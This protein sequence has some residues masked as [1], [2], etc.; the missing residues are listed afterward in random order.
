LVE[1]KLSHEAVFLP[2]VLPDIRGIVP[3]SIMDVETLGK[4]EEAESWGSCSGIQWVAASVGSSVPSTFGVSPG[5]G[6]GVSPDEVGNDGVGRVRRVRWGRANLF[7]NAMV[8]ERNTLRC[9]L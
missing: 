4:A 1:S 2:D 5:E 7:T 8:S 3:S 6:D 9:Y